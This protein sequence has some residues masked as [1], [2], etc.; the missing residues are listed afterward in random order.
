MC[1]QLTQETVPLSEHELCPDA[2]LAGQEVAFQRDI[3]RLRARSAEFITISCPA[4]A[5][6]DASLRFEKYGF[7]Y[8]QCLLCKTIY[9]NPRP[10]PQIMEDYYRHS[11][12]YAYWAQHIF[13]ASEKVRREKIH[14]PW[15][16]RVL[17]Y[18]TRYNIPTRTLVEVGPGVGI[19][20]G[21]A[22]ESGRFEQVITIEPT[23]EMADACRRRGILV[24]NKRIE[25][26][27]DNELSKADIVVSF[28]VIEHLFAPRQFLTQ[29]LKLLAPGGLLVVSCPNGLGFDIAMLGAQALAVDPE[30]VNFFNPNSLT[31]LVEACGF[32]VLE[33]STPGRLDAEFVRDAVLQGRFDISY[34]PFL[35]RVLVDEW[36][37][38]GWP[39]Q[40][41][42]AQHGL[43]SHMWLAARKRRT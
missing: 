42:L 22:M 41:F 20:A 12:N 37:R 4:C 26:L 23:P 35:Q 27:L 6:S 3:E 32:D 8:V 21:L 24:I 13:P 28:E 15:L 2:L 31:L 38:L 33:V 1:F 16:H 10:S 17:E 40:Q 9:M 34:D 11:E 36:D 30:H 14:W 29:C 19:F 5:A 43:S 7:T 18:C 25:D 39:F